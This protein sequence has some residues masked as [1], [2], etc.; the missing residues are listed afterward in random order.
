VPPPSERDDA[1]APDPGRI[2]SAVTDEST[3]P[4]VHTYRLVCVAGSDLGRA[5]R[6]D[7][8]S[9]TIGRSHGE[10]PLGATDVSRTHAR[11]VHD[12]S[13]LVIESLGSANGTFFNGARIATPVKL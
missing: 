5:F 2:P 12:N 6:I 11:I 7:T 9:V 10:V 13:H 8:P 3:T 4:I 1:R